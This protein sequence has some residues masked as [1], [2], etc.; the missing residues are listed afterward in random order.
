M[1][2]GVTIPKHGPPGD[3]HGLRQ[4]RFP[5]VIDPNIWN[6]DFLEENPAFAYGA[7][8]PERGT[9]F[10]GAPRSFFDYYQNRQIPL[11][12]EYVGQ[13]G[14][15]ARSGQPPVATNVDFL[16]NFPWMKRWMALTPEQRGVRS[17]QPLRW[18][19]PR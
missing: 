1:L 4:S 8:R 10:A 16:A 7:Y 2:G 15:A 9:N 14:Q 18:I 12:R 6:T 17:A 3:P 5:S 13:L 19:T 11:E